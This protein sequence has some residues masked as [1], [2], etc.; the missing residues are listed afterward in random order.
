MSLE[1]L[2]KKRIENAAEDFLKKRRLPQELRTK[3]DFGYRI[4]GQSVELFEIRPQWRD[5]GIIQEIPFAKA[6]FVKT[7]KNWNVFWM[8]ADLKWHVYEPHAH[9]KTIDEF[10]NVVHEDENCCFF[11]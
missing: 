11:G 4:V 3:L 10:F 2:Q 7:K 6:T 5:P 8:R 9:M 1:D